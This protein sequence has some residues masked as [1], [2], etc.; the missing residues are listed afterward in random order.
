MQDSCTVYFQCIGEGAPIV[1]NCAE[2][3]QF[4][5][6]TERCDLRD[7]VRCLRE[8]YPLECPSTTDRFTQE[9]HPWACDRFFVCIEGVAE[10]RTCVDG[11]HFDVNK[12]ECR[13]VNLA[14]CILGNDG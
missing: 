4:D 9:P 2:G 11:M 10:E 7:R 3:L 14:E 5:V 6:E 8:V 13:A 1:H 12:R